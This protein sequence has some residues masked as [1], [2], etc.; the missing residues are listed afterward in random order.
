[1]NRFVF[2][3]AVGFIFAQ[4]LR[5]ETT[6]EQAFGALQ[7]RTWPDPTHC[8]HFP[9]CVPSCSL[10]CLCLQSVFGTGTNANLLR[11]TGAFN[12]TGLVSG[13][14]I[15]TWHDCCYTA[16]MRYSGEDADFWYYSAL[17]TRLCFAVAKQ[18]LSRVITMYVYDRSSGVKFEFYQFATTFSCAQCTSDANCLSRPNCCVNFMSYCSPC[19][20]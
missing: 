18:P 5:A 20:Y 19:C 6:Y 7:G 14:G 13:R 8:C 9:N 11:P 3:L 1:M 10:P 15:F 4:V 2:A 12:L 16:Q 17:C